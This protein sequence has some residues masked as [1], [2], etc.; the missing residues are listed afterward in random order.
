MATHYTGHITRGWRIRMIS[1]AVI[2]LTLIIGC[3][4]AEPTAM[5]KSPTV[6]LQPTPTLG[7]TRTRP[8][9]DM[10]MV[11]VPGGT[12][13]MGSTEAEIEDAISLCKQHYTVCNRWY[14]MRASPQHSVSLSSFWLDQT[15][16]TNAQYHQCVEE[17][18]CSE[19]LECEKGEPTYLDDEKSTHPVVCVDW[20]AAGEY[21]EWTGGR[22][23]TEAEWEYAFRGEQ[24]SIYPWGDPFDGAKLNYC[25]VNCELAHADDEYDDGYPRTAPVGS[26]PE[27][28][29]WCG[30]LSMSGNVSEWV[31]DWF[32]DYSP[33]AESDPTGPL[34]GSEKV[35]RGCSWLFHPV[36]CRGAIRASISPDTR[37]DYVGFRCVVQ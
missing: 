2:V 37:F 11:Y 27:G 33:K 24:G 3:G 25:D 4:K 21:C 34:S 15:E 1:P 36:Y 23:P 28:A 16:I 8:T 32:G 5:P 12:F 6:T 10:V 35:V 26:Y 29:S 17:G 30:A 22:L 13:P 20:H 19:P 14:Y 18:I 31:A 9:D 7:N